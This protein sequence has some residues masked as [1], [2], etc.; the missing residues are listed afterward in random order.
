MTDQSKGEYNELG[1]WIVAEAPALAPFG[2]GVNWLA[3]SSQRIVTRLV[4]G[5]WRSRL[6][7]RMV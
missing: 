5:A 1:V 4:M 7:R 3:S 2:G 6:L